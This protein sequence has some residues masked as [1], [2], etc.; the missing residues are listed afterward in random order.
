MLSKKNKNR[1]CVK[2]YILESLWQENDLI[3]L[4][5]IEAY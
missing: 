5:E 2:Q 4:R 1:M 3:I